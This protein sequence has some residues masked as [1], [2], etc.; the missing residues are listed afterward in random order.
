VC[1]GGIQGKFVQGSLGAQVD[2]SLQISSTHEY[3]SRTA[4]ESAHS[5][6]K[7]VL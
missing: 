4:R 1:K 3:F 5:L 7:V 6:W 2:S